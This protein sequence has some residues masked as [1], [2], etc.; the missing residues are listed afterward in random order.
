M[1][2]PNK[3]FENWN[4]TEHVKLIILLNPKGQALT[5]VCIL[6]PTSWVS[7]LNVQIA[8]L[9]IPKQACWPMWP[10]SYIASPNN[11]QN[12]IIAFVLYLNPHSKYCNQFWS[13]KNVNGLILLPFKASNGLDIDCLL[14][15]QAMIVVAKKVQ[16]N[17][18]H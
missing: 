7:N 12:N 3:P 8:D 11:I 14:M 18:F 6:E 13:E 4:W 10:M 5:T 9:W 17:V 16:C 15:K 1:K 2:G